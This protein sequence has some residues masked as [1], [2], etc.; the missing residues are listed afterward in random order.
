MPVEPL[1]RHTFQVQGPNVTAG[2]FST[3]WLVLK[4]D[5]VSR[6]AFAGNHLPGRPSASFVDG[7]AASCPNGT[8]HHHLASVHGPQEMWSHAFFREEVGGCG[9]LL[10]GAFSPS[11]EANFWRLCHLAYCSVMQCLQN[12]EPSWKG[13]CLTPELRRSAFHVQKCCWWILT[14]PGGPAESTTRIGQRC[15]AVEPLLERS[16][17]RRSHCCLQRDF[18]VCS[19]AAGTLNRVTC[20]GLWAAGHRLVPLSS[21]PPPPPPLQKKTEN[22]GA[23]VAKASQPQLLALLLREAKGTSISASC[24]FMWFM[25]LH[26]PSLPRSPVGKTPDMD[27]STRMLCLKALWQPNVC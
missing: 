18:G 7:I 2:I 19:S 26:A 23:L 6:R 4:R 27:D 17:F 20:L 10:P 3:T 16:G 25:C 8:Q 9:S 24:A 22:K 13:V 21:P 5:V 14:V 1:A 11:P 15:G 12:S